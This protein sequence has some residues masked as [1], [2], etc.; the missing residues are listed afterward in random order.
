MSIKIGAVTEVGIEMKLDNT[1]LVSLIVIAT[2]G[3]EDLEKRL[4]KAIASLQ[5]RYAFFEILL[6]GT[7]GDAAVNGLVSH[8]GRSVPQLRVLQLEGES[9]F[10]RMAM[11]GYHECIGDAVVMSSADEVGHVDLEAIVEHLRGGEELVR[12]RRSR[13]NALERFGSFIVRSVT[14]LHVDTRFLRTLGLNRRLLSELLARPEEIH[15]FRFTAHDFL[16][17]HAVIVTDEPP[18]RSGFGFFIGRLDLVT[19]LI[20]TSA[21]RLLRGASALCLLLSGAALITLIY[22]VGVWLFREEIAEGWTTLILL[23]ASWMFVQLLASS[24]LCLG[25]SRALDGQE[26]ART[27]R[28]VDETTVSDLFSSATLLNVERAD[29]DYRSFTPTRV[30]A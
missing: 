13:G 23:L 27:P 25:L 26:R 21:P 1:I 20:A 12:L 17:N 9:N 24:A 16:S 5:S 30:R 4:E 11:Q 28:L 8:L 18:A 6:I 10:D 3:F 14:G 19:R 15:L 2:Q 22:V 7:S 29:D